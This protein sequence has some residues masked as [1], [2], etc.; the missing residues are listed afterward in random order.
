MPS[1]KLS[2]FDLNVHQKPPRQNHASASRRGPSTRNN[3]RFLKG[4]IPLNWLVKAA[5]LNGKALEIAV[6]IW[7]LKG[8]KR[9][10]TVKLNGKLLRE[11]KISRSTLYRGLAAMEKAGLIS[12]QRQIGRSPM[13]TILIN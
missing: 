11:F 3:N 6:V 13:V 4:P 5:P 10:N 7:H 9:K 1:I 2:D 8:L 12:I